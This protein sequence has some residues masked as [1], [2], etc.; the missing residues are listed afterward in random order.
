MDKECSCPPYHIT[1]DPSAFDLDAIHAYLTNSYWVPGIPKELVARSIENALCFGVFEGTK[2]IGFARVVTDRATVAYLG[3]VYILEA[4]QGQGLG[5]WLM[6]TIVSHPDL[7][8]LRR[9]MLVTHD[10]HG[11]Y[12]QFG[13]HP[14]DNPEGYMERRDI[15]SYTDV[16]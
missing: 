5:K 12:R 16:A 4:Y 15:R 7:Q 14:L 13:F 2:Q 11:L 6:Q 9:W 10:A 8:G 3:D 1:T